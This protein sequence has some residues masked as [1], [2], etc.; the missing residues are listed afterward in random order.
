MNRL[1]AIS[2]ALVFPLIAAMPA[3]DQKPRRQRNRPPLIDSFTSSSTMVEICP[4]SPISRPEANLTVNA[5]DLDGDSLQ[6]EY[7]TTE[8]TIS[9][10]GDF[11][12]WDLN[13][14]KRGP[15]EVRV[16]VTDGKGGKAEAALTVTTVDGGSCDPPP[17][18]CPEIKVSCPAEMEKSKPFIFSVLVIEGKADP[19]NPPSFQ[20]NL[21]AG[22]IVKGQ[23]NREIEAT[24]TGANGFENITATVVVDGFDPSCITTASC[25]TKIIW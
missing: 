10:K 13:N 4:W 12:T 6:Y 25:T 21:S 9:G 22:R 17:P 15:H 23:N 8:G 16:T 19:Y 3:A 2:F 14:V 1:L 7:A 24:T 5:T 11:V 18:P 20:W